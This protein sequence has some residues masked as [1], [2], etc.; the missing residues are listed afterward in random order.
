MLGD[1]L[2]MMYGLDHSPVK[3]D[4]DLGEPQLRPLF[5]ELAAA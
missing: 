3:V 4:D 2:T 5:E 1:G